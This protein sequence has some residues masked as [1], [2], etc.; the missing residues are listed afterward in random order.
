MILDECK[1]PRLAKD[2]IWGVVTRG[3]VTMKM[4][5]T[6]CMTETII[7]AEDRKSSLAPCMGQKTETKAVLKAKP[8]PNEAESAAE[9]DAIRGASSVARTELKCISV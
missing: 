4:A 2:G 9:P 1:T 5:L 6:H 7:A 8:R 3:I